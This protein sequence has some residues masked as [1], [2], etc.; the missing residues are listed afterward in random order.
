[1][2]VGTKTAKLV[3][4]RCKDKKNEAVHMSI[5]ETRTLTF[6]S[7]RF[8]DWCSYVWHW[9]C[10]FI[11]KKNLKMNLVHVS[12][13]DFQLCTNFLAI[14]LSE[15]NI[16]EYYLHLFMMEIIFVNICKS[17]IETWLGISWIWKQSGSKRDITK[18]YYSS[19]S[20]PRALKIGP[21][22]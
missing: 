6:N 1:M 21:H 10:S 13:R 2:S 20:C 12:I 8:A 5:L 18:V 11:I 9:K 16:Y 15:P 19:R 17:Q 22:I 4:R 14:M 3:A 7:G